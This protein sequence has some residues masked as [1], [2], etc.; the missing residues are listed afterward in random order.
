METSFQKKNKQNLSLKWLFFSQMVRYFS[1]N[2]FILN[3]IGEKLLHK[4]KRWEAYALLKRS[5]DIDANQKAAQLLSKIE[6]PPLPKIATIEISTVCNLG[7]P[8]CRTGSGILNRPPKFMRFKE[9]C[10][11][12][13]K[14][15]E[16]TE[17]LIIVG[18]G[19]TFLNKDIYKIIEY[20]KRD[21]PYVFIDTHG[22]VDM[23]HER[24]INS[25]LDEIEFSI[26]GINQ[27]MYEKYR[28][29][30]N[31]KRVIQNLQQLVQ[32]K[33]KLKA[34]KPNIVFKFIVFRHTEMHLEDAEKLA[35]SLGVDEFR[36]EPCVFQTVYGEEKLRRFLP[37]SPEWQ[38]IEY[39][40]FEKE[41]IGVPKVYDS[42]HCNIV[43]TNLNVLID[44]S[45]DFCCAINND[46][47][48]A[49]GNLFE[50]SLSEI[51]YS[52]AANKFRLKVLK[53]R[54]ELK[55]CHD[56]SYPKKDFSKFLIAAKLAK[57]EIEKEVPSTRIYI[58][59]LK[60]SSKEI[61]R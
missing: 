6:N 39:V 57:P 12:W 49:Q 40:D 7:C 60:D 23:D 20:A 17:R 27:E 35:E 50:K 38:K 1:N 56:C 59:D 30:G 32:A 33:H 2:T 22:N 47:I 61:R 9:F 5:Y 51:W 41:I 36:I 8:L 15:K 18:Q 45:V 46:Y 58:K 31:F 13:E 21:N 29:K 16:S 44:G 52:E 54:W 53:D 37:H 55:A 4:R 19:E 3:L 24:I 25:G 42:K 10:Q 34:A 48:S 28:V 43:F 26:D 14:V 11:I